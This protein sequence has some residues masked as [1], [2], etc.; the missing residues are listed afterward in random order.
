[1]LSS[2][3]GEGV[4]LL[5]VETERFGDSVNQD[6]LPIHDVVPASIGSMQDKVYLQPV[7]SVEWCRNVSRLR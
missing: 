7:G 4:N 3:D 5:I 6:L 2:G 1:M